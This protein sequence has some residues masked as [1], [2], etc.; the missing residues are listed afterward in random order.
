MMISESLGT[1]TMSE[2]T[3]RSS[4]HASWQFY[5]AGRIVFG[6]GCVEQLGSLLREL[7]VS[8]PLIITDPILLGLGL[9]QPALDSLR[10][11]G[12][13]PVVFDQGE[14]EPAVEV[15]DR[16]VA[17]GRAHTPDCV[18]GIG[19]GSNM[20]V[21]KYVAAALTHGGQP[22]DYFGVDKVPGPVLPLVAIPTTSGTGSEVSHAAVLT[23]TTA[24]VKVSCL[25]NHL[26]PR[27]ALVD[28][29]LTYQCPAKVMAH[30]GIDALTHAIE[31]CTNVDYDQ[32]QTPGGQFAA[33]YGRFPIGDCLGE[34]AIRIIGHHLEPAVLVPQSRQA[35]D[36]MSLAATLAGMA[37]SNCGV[38]I[39]HALEYPIGAA[40]HCSHGEGNGCL[41]PYVM[42]FIL[43]VRT[44][45]LA[46]IGR[47]LGC[48]ER[49]DDRLM[50]E[51]A[52]ERVVQIRKR[53]GIA[54]QL[55]ELG[56]ER[57]QIPGFANKSWQ[58]Q[59]LMWLCARRPTEQDLIDILNEAY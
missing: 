5:S 11:V 25:S 37:F 8:Q 1:S 9:V 18:I 41:L 21:A 33:Y 4:R 43:P 46:D 3:E 49:G 12:I 42:R 17:L 34:R 35:R 6:P 7:K 58:I 2:P 53:I 50:A 16:A 24:Q 29:S 57:S 36:Q 38:G 39:V 55:R 44:R 20:D 54:H 14:A 13:K 22:R 56:V 28:P 30:S 48:E 31:A 59:R 15:A 19:G 47:A 52:I 32:L 23:D 51:A 27:I 45:E 40:V 10:A 26:R